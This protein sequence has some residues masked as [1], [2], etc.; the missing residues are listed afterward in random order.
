M[1]DCP[2]CGPNEVIALLNKVNRQLFFYCPSCFGAWG[3]I[4][5]SG[6]LAE[7]SPLER[8]A[9]DGVTYPSIEDLRL[10]GIS[11]PQ[12][13]TEYNKR[14][15]VKMRQQVD[16]F[17]RGEMELG[18]LIGD[19]EFLLN[20]MESMDM[21]WKAEIHEEVDTM[22]Q[23]YA[24]ALAWSSGRLDETDKSLV[25]QSVQNISEGLSELGI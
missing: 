20:V 11:A 24:V 9:P 13:I 7:T 6:A 21:K 1:G 22:E 3:K 25:S 10:H 8:F 5:K 16:S 23:V 4:P 2:D 15:L 18:S 17:K 12:V 19:L 14:Q